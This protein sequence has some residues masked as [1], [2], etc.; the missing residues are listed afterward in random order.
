MGKRKRSKRGA[1]VA[2]GTDG[3]VYEV[4]R[5]LDQRLVK[6]KRQFLVRWVGWAPEWD[7]WESEDNIHTPELIADL[8]ARVALSLDQAKPRLQQTQSQHGQDVDRL[9]QTQ[10]QHGQDVDRFEEGAGQTAIVSDGVDTF[11]PEAEVPRIRKRSH[12]ATLGDEPP[13]IEGF[14]VV[15]H[16]TKIHRW[17]P[18]SVHS[19]PQ[20]DV[21]T[22]SGAMYVVPS[23]KSVRPSLPPVLPQLVAVAGT[24]T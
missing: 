1:A 24:L 5:L 22:R 2:A 6:G 16:F 18:P 3:E 20:A 9:Q 8:N 23:P 13:C 14:S 15:L 21:P 4:E 12:V 7:S 19:A 10:S 11:S 17:T